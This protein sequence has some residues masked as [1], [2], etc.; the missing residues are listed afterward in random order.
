M[1]EIPTLRYRLLALPNRL[2][3][4]L[5]PVFPPGRIAWGSQ[6]VL[7]YCPKPG[8]WRAEEITVKQ[9]P[10]PY[11]MSREL[12]APFRRWLA[13]D[14]AREVRTGTS[15]QLCADPTAFSDRPE[16]D[17]TVAA[18]KYAETAYFATNVAKHEDDRRAFVRALVT[19]GSVGFAHSFCLHAVVATVDG[20]VLLTQ[21][22]TK[23]FHYKEA[24]SVSIEERLGEEDLNL[25]PTEVVGHWAR[26]MLREELGLSEAEA[27]AAQAR[28]LAV[29][30]EADILNCALAAVVTLGLTRAELNA[31]IESRVRH[32]YEFQDWTFVRWADLAR[33]LLDGG[34]VY[35][36][37]AGLRMYLAGVAHFGVYGFGVQL[38]RVRPH[39]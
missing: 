27:T 16:L 15:Y 39:G 26:R 3:R 38:Q 31:I 21:R 36:P 4:I 8:G 25:A 10:A 32:D 1:D 34:R 35:H 29:F 6:L 7:Q 23:V 5:R 22:S 14:H 18:N 17:L 12:A 19:R 30:L 13:T 28:F 2:Y 33:E 20:H 9:R 37:S 11:R 24:W